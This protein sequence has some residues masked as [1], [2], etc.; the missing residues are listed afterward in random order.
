MLHDDPVEP[1]SS[2][3]KE[4]LLAALAKLGIPI[5][6]D[7]LERLETHFALMIDANRTMN[8]T[9]I[10]EPAE[11]AIKHYAD[12]LAL[13]PWAATV[14]IGKA[15]LLDIGTGAGFPAVPLAVMRPDWSITAIDGTKKKI[16]FVRRVAAEIGLDHLA[17]QHGHSD[18]WR[19]GSSFDIVVTRAVALLAQCIHT[20]RPHLAIGGRFVAYK[21]AEVSAEETKH[22]EIV[23]KRSRLRIEFPY[24]YELDWGGE[25]LLRSL[26]VA[27][28][29]K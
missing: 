12:S 5:T 28:G 3:F 24:Y 26:R 22:G 15:T 11:A 1:G 7:Q 25:R 9:R 13:L 8:L 14:D 16:D 19:G 23:A 18:H 21:T 29:M 6:V 17:V 2:I 4:T 10:T 20:A 27:S